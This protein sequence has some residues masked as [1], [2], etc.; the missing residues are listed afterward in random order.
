[1]ICSRFVQVF[2]QFLSEFPLSPSSRREE[3]RSD[4]EFFF[5]SLR[6]LTVRRWLAKVTSF[7]SGRSCTCTPHHLLLLLLPPPPRCCSPRIAPSHLGFSCPLKLSIKAASL[8]ARG[9]G[10]ASHAVRLSLDLSV[11]CTLF[12]PYH[13]SPQL[14]S[15]F[16]S[17]VHVCESRLTTINIVGL[18]STATNASHAQLQTLNTR[19]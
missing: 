18:M 8:C 4:F 12:G 2:L 6:F 5:P 9:A 3:K 11:K 13:H 7:A 17:L 1:M 14:S 10:F 15:A 19:F 16:I